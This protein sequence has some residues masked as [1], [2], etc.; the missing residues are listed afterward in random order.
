AILLD[1]DKRIEAINDSCL[2]YFQKQVPG[3]VI[4]GQ[5]VVVDKLFPWLG[6]D[7]FAIL[8]DGV[9]TKE[10]EAIARRLLDSVA[11]YQF[12]TP[13]NSFNLCLSIGVAMITRKIDPEII[14]SKADT[15]MYQAK[16]NGGNQFLL[17]E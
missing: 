16:E 17:Y 1:L 3:E 6:G 4:Y 15:A 11:H 9:Q 10:A 5:K 8:L 2:E 14:M 7:E 12:V 13:E